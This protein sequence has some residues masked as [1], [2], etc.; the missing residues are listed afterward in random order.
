[1]PKALQP[2]A[3]KIFPVLIFV[4]TVMDALSPLVHEAGYA[5]RVYKCVSRGLH[6]NFV[7]IYIIVDR[8]IDR[9]YERRRHTERH[10][11]IESELTKRVRALEQNPF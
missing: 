8:Q 2:Y 6:E 7:L 9:V 4:G 3:A 10:T 5:Q 11:H 1:M